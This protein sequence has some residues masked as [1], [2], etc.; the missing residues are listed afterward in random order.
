MAPCFIHVTMVK[1]KNTNVYTLNCIV[2]KQQRNKEEQ[3][4]IHCN[5]VSYHR[6][7]QSFQAYL[8]FKM[9]LNIFQKVKKKE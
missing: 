6:E 8:H 1:K 7:A 3:F 5:L 9:L 4:L 2:S